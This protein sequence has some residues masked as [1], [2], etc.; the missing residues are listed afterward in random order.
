MWRRKTWERIPQFFSSQFNTGISRA[1]DFV[2]VAA[3]AF[4]GLEEMP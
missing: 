2:G 1:F 4:V 3:V